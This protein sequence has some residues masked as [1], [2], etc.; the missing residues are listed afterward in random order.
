MSG[1][2]R[3]REQRV[4][5]YR[6]GALSPRARAAFERARDED[7]CPLRPL[8]VMR[9]MILDIAGGEA[10]PHM[11]DAFQSDG[12]WDLGVDRLEDGRYGAVQTYSLDTETLAQTPLSNAID[13]IN[14]RFALVCG[15]G[16]QKE[17][18]GIAQRGRAWC[19]PE[20]HIVQRCQLGVGS[21]RV[22][23]RQQA[24][25][26]VQRLTHLHTLLV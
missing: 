23:G 3:T 20:T 1:L 18:R 7:V 21:V 15:G 19:R 10:S 2:R 5:A 25:T 9:Q 17:A 12:R 26:S 4:D 6:D 11:F 24:F 16:R 13:A 14:G 8:G 22:H